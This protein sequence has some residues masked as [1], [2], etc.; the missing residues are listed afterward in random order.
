MTA[1]EKYKAEL[2][3][4]E[5]D[6][7]TPTAGAMIGHILSNLHIQKNK[8]R[9]GIYAVK[10]VDSSFVREEFSRILREEDR[11]F[12]ELSFLMLDEGEVIPTTTEEFKQYTMLTESGQLKY[13]ES[14][15]VL[16]GAA[17]DFD[18]QNLFITRGIALAEKENKYALAVF[19]K[20]LYGWM[21]HQIFVVQR[22]L[23][24]EVSFG[25]SEEEDD[26]D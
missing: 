23:G 26:E 15:D 8:L 12:D 1:E 22:Y 16:F 14:R 24:N 9:Q 19:L 17:K 13:E 6:H 10:G 3:Q 11:L 20:K 21:K 7:H 5:K 25:L 18:T 2:I 4:S